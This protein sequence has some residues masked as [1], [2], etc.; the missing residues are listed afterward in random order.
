MKLSKPIAL[1]AA[2]AG[3]VLAAPVIADSYQFRTS[4]KGLSPKAEKASGDSCKSILDAVGSTGSGIY[5]ITPNGGPEI[6][7]YCDMESAGGGWTMIV[8]QFEADP[9]ESWNEGI[10]TDYD[11]SLGSSKSFTLNTSQIP[12]HSEVAF[13]KGLDADFIGS[14]STTYETGDIFKT[15]LGN[16]G[17]QYHIFRNTAYY[18]RYLD[19]D[20]GNT[21]TQATWLDSLT[22]DPIGRLGFSWSFSPKAT[23][24]VPGYAM[25][26]S[27]LTSSYEPYAWTVWVR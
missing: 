14:A 1:S 5:S 13:G 19:P 10:Q 15:V 23:G 17:Q 25:G 4:V 16:D 22:F 24:A 6:D 20:N 12:V 2:L 7:V 27:H 9:A 11:P 21:G 26:G 18:F 3:V 8:A